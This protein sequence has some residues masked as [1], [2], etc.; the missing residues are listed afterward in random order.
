M[1]ALYKKELSYYLNSPIGYVVV[2]LFAIFVNFFYIKDIFL[3]GSASMR[4]FFSLLPWFFLAFIP[5][6]S[7][8]IF[9]EEKRLNTLESLLNLPISE[10]TIVMTKYFALT[11]ILLIGLLL[12]MALPISLSTLSKLYLPQVLV[13]YLGVFLLG[14]SYIAIS[15]FFSSLTKNQVVAF[16]LSVCFL[17]FLTVLSSDFLAGVLPKTIQDVASVF[18]P[19]YQ[20]DSFIKGVI[21]VRSVVYFVSLTSLFL[22][23]T[24]IVI[25]RRD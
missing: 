6:I 17:F 1:K 16:L 22:F 25:E 14:A 3:V 21:D 4:P 5:A 23:L 19:L 2:I 13:G 12:T 18:G 15:M 24:V 20:V 11:S 10:S 7:M 8:R 9:S